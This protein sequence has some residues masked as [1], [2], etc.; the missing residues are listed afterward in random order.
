MADKPAIRALL[1]D[2]CIVEMSEMG[3]VLYKLCLLVRLS[4]FQGN[5]A[6]KMN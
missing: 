5:E 4:L 1:S 2:G 6:L 3:D